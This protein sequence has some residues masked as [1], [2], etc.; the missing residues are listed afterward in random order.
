[1]LLKGT[2]TKTHNREL[3]E[4]VNV[5][6]CHSTTANCCLFFSSNPVAKDQVK[7][8]VAIDIMHAIKKLHQKKKQQKLIN[9]NSVRKYSTVKKQ[10]AVMAQNGVCKA[11]PPE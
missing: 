4:K 6:F 1:M 8:N 9:N 5:L 3:V 2:D 11:N 7:N 10:Q